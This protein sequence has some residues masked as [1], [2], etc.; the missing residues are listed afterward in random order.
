M[1]ALQ[2]FYELKLVIIFYVLKNLAESDMKLSVAMNITNIFIAHSALNRQEGW[3]F[4][5]KSESKYDDLLPHSEVCWLSKG[6]ILNRFIACKDEIQIFLTETGETYLPLNDETWQIQLWLLTNITDHFNS[7]S[8][9]LQGNY[10]IL[11]IYKEWQFSCRKLTYLKILQLWKLDTPKQGQ[12]VH[13][14]ARS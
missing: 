5:G 10:I 13:V 12:Q 6:K 3:N 11:G 2:S 1:L 4:S 9:Y 7:F 14:T 8:L